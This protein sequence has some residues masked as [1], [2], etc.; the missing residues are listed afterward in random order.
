V[1]YHVIFDATDQPFWQA[2]YNVF[3]VF[4]VV[5]ALILI[6][7]TL[8]QQLLP[9]GAQGALRT[10]LGGIF[11]IVP[12]IIGAYVIIN[13]YSYRQRVL[14]WLRDGHVQVTEGPVTDFVPMP[15]EG[16]AQERFTVRGHT[17]S[18]SDYVLSP[19]FHNT[20]SHGGPIREGLNVRVTFAGNL[21]LRLEVAQ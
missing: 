5:G 10:M 4:P 20:A 8:M 12:P 21:I 16:H 2:S 17:F 11:L 15:Y 6:F 13:A 14:E 18:Y 19:G 1:S 7:P 3:F 9:R